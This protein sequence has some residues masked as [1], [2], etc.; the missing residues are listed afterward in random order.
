MYFAPLLLVPEAALLVLG[1]AL[2]VWRW[3][4]PAAFLM[5]LSGLGVLFVGGTLVSYPNASFPQLNHWTP[6][7]PAI[8]AGI[9]VALGAFATSLEA[10]QSSTRRWVVPAT[11]GAAIALLALW[12][13]TYY[14]ALYKPDASILKSDN[15]RQAQE[16]YDVQNA[17]SRYIASLDNAYRA[18]WVGPP[19]RPYD[20]GVTYA[21]AGREPDVVRLANP[22]SELTNLEPGTSELERRGLA[23]IIFPEHE[24]YRPLVEASFPGGEAGVVY[25][26]TGKPLFATYEV[27][28]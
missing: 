7:Y 18:V 22:Q 17:Q 15:Y 11:M 24:Q 21:L 25:G 28:P 14:F 2:M 9:A 6:A 26:P 1:F 19:T 13:V 20:A 23:F 5:L 10:W 8:Y 16:Y 4:H 27:R 3:K 12:N